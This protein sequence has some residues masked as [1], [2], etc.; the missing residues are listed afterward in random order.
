MRDYLKV[1]RLFARIAGEDMAARDRV[2]EVRPEYYSAMLERMATDI[3]KGTSPVHCDKALIQVLLEQIG[4]FCD[5][6]TQLLL[7]GETAW[8]PAD[9]GFR[10]RRYGDELIVTEAEKD[11]RF[12]PG[13]II[14]KV[15]NNTIPEYYNQV[16]RTL[17]STV[18]ENEDWLIALQFSNT[19]HVRRERGEER[20]PLMRFPF[21]PPD[22]R[23]EISFRDGVCL[24]RLDSLSDADGIS[25]MLLQNAASIRQSRGVVVDLRRCP[26][27][28]GGC[29]ALL[30][31]LADRGTRQSELMPPEEIYLLYTPENKRLLRAELEA[32]LPSAETAAE[33]QEMEALIGEIDGKTGWVAERIEEDEDPEIPPI[34]CRRLV[35]L[36]DRETGS[37]AERFA[38]AVRRLG[39]GTVIGRHTL[40]ALDFVH[41]LARPLDGSLT[42]VYSCGMRAEAY[43]GRRINGT[44]LAPDIHIPWSPRFLP[45]D[46]DLEAALGRIDG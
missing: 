1:Q 33:R 5:P 27:C 44:G 8:R 39:R 21:D 46:P 36:T 29:G 11:R 9:P 23:T 25:R 34:P 32:L 14:T 35:V 30:P 17:R 26:S 38:E 28:R 22:A 37:D 6:G 4:A 15:Q 20:L 41:P 12:V 3:V 13:D 2:R 42:L 7:R 19:V 10:V 45:E 18:Q 43:N 16:W 31:L 24:L 40:G